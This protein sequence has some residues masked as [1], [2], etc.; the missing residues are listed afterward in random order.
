MGVFLN[1][2]YYEI[3]CEDIYYFQDPENIYWFN[4]I[5]WFVLAPVKGGYRYKRCK[6]LQCNKP[7]VRLFIY[8]SSVTL[9]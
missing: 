3:K 5:Y 7:A 6:R 2:F 8:G 4:H 1:L 9:L